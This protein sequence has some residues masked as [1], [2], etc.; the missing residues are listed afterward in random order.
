MMLVDGMMTK[1]TKNEEN[2]SRHGMMP[3]YFKTLKEDKGCQRVPK[4]AN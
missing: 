3:K 2:D 1:D 4:D